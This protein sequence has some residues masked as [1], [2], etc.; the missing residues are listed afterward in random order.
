MAAPKKKTAKKR[1]EKNDKPTNTQAIPEAPALESPIPNVKIVGVMNISIDDIGGTRRTDRSPREDDEARLTELAASL[2][3]VGQ[4]QN[5]MVEQIGLTEEPYRLVFGARRIQAARRLGWKTITALVCEPMTSDQRRTC[6]A[7]ENIQRRDLTPPEETLAVND[8]LALQALPAA[9]EW[10]KPLSGEL[11]PNSILGRTGR[12]LAEAKIAM[13]AEAR[14]DLLTQN[15]EVMKIAVRH[16][17]AMLAKSE[18]WVRDR[19]YIGRLDSQS[20]WL[21]RDGRLPLAHAREI[22]KLTDPDE[23]IALAEAFAAGGRLSVSATEP[24][25]YDDLREEVARRCFD[26]RQAPWRLDMAWGDYHAC[27]DCPDNSIQQPGLFDMDQQ[28][29]VEQRAGL[30]VGKHTSVSEKFGACTNA[31]CFR[32]KALD[33]KAVLTREGKRLSSEVKNGKLTARPDPDLIVPGKLIATRAVE[34]AAKAKTPE[35][36]KRAQA[37]VTDRQRLQEAM[38]QIRHKHLAALHDHYQAAEPAIGKA[39]SSTPG[40]WS[41]YQLVRSTKLWHACFA[42]GPKGEA[43]AKSQTLRDLLN[44]IL[45]PCYDNLIMIEKHCGRMFDLVRWNESTSGATQALLDALGIDA[46]GEPP[47]MRDVLPEDLRPEYGRWLAGEATP[48]RPK[49]GRS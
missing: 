4:L 37:P 30:G 6:I 38:V 48:K 3:T 27:I 23:R 19:L 5:I 32:A 22:A 28:C 34:I 12:E 36:L 33:A 41:M 26:L 42:Q 31:P 2:K 7:I 10:G 20:Q 16:V 9:I 8:L 47:S 39:L 1:T 17:A 29:S 43:A 13:S 40:A 49:G 18:G 21:V 44:M 15:P 25:R 11:A 35:K 24:G 46:G 14:R 45:D